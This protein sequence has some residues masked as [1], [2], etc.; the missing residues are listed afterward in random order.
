MASEA[1]MGIAVRLSMASPFLA[2]ALMA[3]PAMSSPVGVDGA[4]TQSDA[5][6]A[7]ASAPDAAPHH[8]SKTCDGETLTY[9]TAGSQI[10]C[11]AVGA[12]CLPFHDGGWCVA[13]VG[14]PCGSLSLDG[15]SFAVACAGEQAGC[16]FNNALL[17]QGVCAEQQPAC[18][19]QH[20]VCDSDR[21]V[22]CDSWTH[23]PRVID[24][25]ASF[26]TTCEGSSCLQR[27]PG[28]V[29]DAYSH[30]VVRC[31]PPMT[32]VNVDS[33]GWGQCQVPDAG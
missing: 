6:T 16:V 18:V 10:S 11:T 19:A 5:G 2:M 29:C 9:T 12:S 23:Q 4:L 21:Q 17:D 22:R 15:G 32:C 7:D 20:V 24:C 13:P 25:A 31:E 14:S 33:E 8:T 28:T 27:T 26:G 1:S 3:C 30:P